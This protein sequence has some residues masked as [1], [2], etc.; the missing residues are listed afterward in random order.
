MD[1]SACVMQC[2]EIIGGN[3]A[4]RQTIAAPGLD[5]WVD[6]RPLGLGKGG[7]DV[8]YISTCGAG[9]V[10]R[11]ALADIAGHGESVDG[12]AI[13]LRKL[14]RKYINT[15]DQTRFA[16]AL[17]RELAADVDFGRFATALLLTYFAP[18]RHL[19]IC[20][21]GHGRPLR[22]SAR[23]EKWESLDL[24]SADACPSL[25]ASRSR[26]HLERLANLPLGVLEPME[27]EQLAVELDE[28]DVVVLFTDAV[29]EATDL[30]GHMLGE[31]GLLSLVKNLA[32]GNVAEL[33]ERL[34]AEIDRR[35]GKSS[36]ADD[37]TV[38]VIKRAE[39]PLPRA[40]LLRT[41]R[42]LAKLVGLSRV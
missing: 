41:A 19:I 34:V 36:D 23:H 27:Y 17:N 9:F 28:G 13:A 12:F 6:S 42:T 8:H 11:L 30:S 14:M 40:S 3:R 24:Q 16:R 31:S 7:G 1:K 33:G 2:M 5:I 22:Y 21:A 20:N 38:I 37:Q 18:T 29:T 26:Y 10:T 35:R 25:K 15:L 32:P 39:T 4:E